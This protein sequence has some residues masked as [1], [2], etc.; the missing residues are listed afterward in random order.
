[1]L[2]I[3]VIDAKDG[4]YKDSLDEEGRIRRDR[5]MPRAALKNLNIRR[6]NT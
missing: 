4:T 1:M 3:A 2:F 5:R 6:S